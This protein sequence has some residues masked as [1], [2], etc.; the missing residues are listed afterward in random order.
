MPEQPYPAINQP[1]KD[2]VSVA[3]SAR[4]AGITYFV[5]GYGSSSRAR[6]DVISAISGDSRGIGGGTTTDTSLLNTGCAYPPTPYTNGTG[7]RYRYQPDS[8]QWAAQ[9]AEIAGK[10]NSTFKSYVLNY[11]T[12]AESKGIVASF[13]DFVLNFVQGKYF[14]RSYANETN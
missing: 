6:G 5:A 9:Y 8:L 13:T 2:A 14:D 7:C 3:Q 10:I 4:S 1:M 11:Q 12:K